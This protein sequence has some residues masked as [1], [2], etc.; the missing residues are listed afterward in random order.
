MSN[1][2]TRLRL[3]GAKYILASCCYILALVACSSDDEDT[4]AEY[5]NWQARNDAYFEEIFQTATSEINN[6][7]EEWYK[8]L[9]YSKNDESNH[10]NFIVVHVL[11][12]SKEAH[13]EVVN[14][15][16]NTDNGLT[17]PLPADSC[18]ITYRGNMMPS[19]SYSTIASPD[20][21]EVGY[22]FDTKWYGDVLNKDEA[23]YTKMTA[24]GVVEGFG[25]ALQYMHPGDRWRVYIPYRLGYKSSASGS[26]QAYSTL[27]FDIYL[28]S[29]KSKQK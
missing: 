9:S 17:C 7:S 22:Q 26:V 23:I 19:A 4:T 27:I 2:K 13:K 24:A 5:Y 3:S 29:F 25:T 21:I 10:K 14:G 18:T 11:E 16:R 6:G 12:Q 8:I 15:T 20:N 28:K 1:P